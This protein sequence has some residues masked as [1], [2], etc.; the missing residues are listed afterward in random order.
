MSVPESRRGHG[1]FEV[2]VKANDLAVY[3]IRIASNPKTF[4]VK[5]QTALA[6]DIIRTAKDIY[7]KCKTANDIRVGED[8]Y[9]A[10]M[11]K[12]LQES[13]IIDC[14]TLLALMDMAKRVYHLSAKRLKYW[15]KMTIEVRD[16]IRRWK[17][18]DSK[19]YPQK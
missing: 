13:A 19:R 6:D 10:Q 2:L 7:I 12:R 3:T 9:K 17:D 4:D 8:P 16:M 14:C 18:S 11:R 5:Y 15:G 1:K